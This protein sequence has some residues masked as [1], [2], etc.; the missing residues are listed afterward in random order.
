MHGDAIKTFDI[1]QEGLSSC[2]LK[3]NFKPHKTVVLVGKC[4]SEVELQ[5]R[6][7]DY[8]R[9]GFHEANIK[10]HPLNGGSS[11]TY[12]YVHLGVPV[13]DMNYCTH[14]LGKLVT[15]FEE[16]CDCDLAVKSAQQKWVYLLWVIR[17]KFTYWFR[18]MSPNITKQFI[19]R[20]T[21]ILKKKFT[22]LA[23]FDVTDNYWQQI[24]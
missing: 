9:R 11:D 17:Q 6:D 21:G 8:Q 18:N 3:V 10:I 15:Q 24:C 12:G 23:N 16:T 14:E 22:D 2:G 19:D 20:I 4:N 13:G 5:Q 7:L 1:L